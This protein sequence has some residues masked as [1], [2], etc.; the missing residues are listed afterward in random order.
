MDAII[1]KIQEFLTLYGIKVVAA[2]AILILGRWVAKAIR[3]I[4]RRFMTKRN[5]DETLV[6][7]LCDLT[8][9]GLIVFV[10]I[11][12]LSQLGI[13]TTSI[14]AVLGAAGL[15]V[16]LALQGSLSNFASGVLMI[17]FKPFKVGDYIEAAGVGGT[18]VAI[19][20]FATQLNSPDNRKIIVPNSKISGDNIVNYTA[21]TTRRVDLVVGVSYSDDL[22]QV[23]NTLNAIL[24]EDERV[25]KD[26]APVVA[27][28]ELGDSSINFAV[29]PWVKTDDYWAVYF[30]LHKK[31]KE[32][33]DAEGISIPFPQRD[34]HMIQEGGSA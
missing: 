1:V 31:I 25:L 8:Y 21:H 22:N 33:F 4:L 32:R 7:F 27:V 14:I 29:R 19:G 23:R 15:A 5:V 6:P 17:I 28:L 26:P 13:Q 12:S 3:G 9:A 16:A 18:V 20:I 30:D 11:A 24:A 34:V 2:L 10:V